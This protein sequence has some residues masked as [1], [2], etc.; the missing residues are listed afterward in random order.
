MTKDN[1]SSGFTKTKQGE[2]SFKFAFFYLMLQ[3]MLMSHTSL[4]FFVLSFVLA[5]AYV[6]SKEQTLIILFLHFLARR[7]RCGKTQNNIIFIDP[8]V[9]GHQT[10]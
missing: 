2:F 7:H 10:R 4:H 3:L 5:C 8:N 6:A 1:F 9:H